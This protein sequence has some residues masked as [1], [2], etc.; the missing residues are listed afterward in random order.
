MV[1][2]VRQQVAS[3]KHFLLYTQY[4]LLCICIYVYL[5]SICYGDGGR[6]RKKA[7]KLSSAVY[8]YIYVCRFFAYHFSY[9]SIS[10]FLPISCLLRLNDLLF[11]KIMEYKTRENERKRE[12]EREM[13]T[14]IYYFQAPLSSLWYVTF[15]SRKTCTSTML[16]NIQRESQR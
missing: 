16:L 9:F 15:S 14:N 4:L 7:G 11:Q 5:S 6:G 12:R 10:V 8:H 2:R 1:K 13:L 3:N